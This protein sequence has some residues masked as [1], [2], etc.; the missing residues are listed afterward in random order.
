[1]NVYKQEGADYLGSILRFPNSPKFE[2]Q[3][4]GQEQEQLYMN[5]QTGAESAFDRDLQ[6]LWKELEF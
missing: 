1:M 5:L 2:L 3:A 4:L 6:A